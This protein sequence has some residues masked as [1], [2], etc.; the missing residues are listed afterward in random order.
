MKRVA[1]YFA[2]ADAASVGPRPCPAR[3]RGDAET[4]FIPDYRDEGSPRAPRATAHAGRVC[5]SGFPRLAGQHERYVAEQL[6]QFR[7]G[8][9]S[10]D[11]AAMMC[12]NSPPTFRT[13]RS[14]RCRR[15]WHGFASRWPLRPGP[16]SMDTCFKSSN[17]RAAG[18]R[19]SLA[20][21]FAVLLCQPLVAG[22]QA[23]AA[24]T[25]PRAELG[26]GQRATIA[27][28]ERFPS[29]LRRRRPR[30]AGRP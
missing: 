23:R 28:R 16:V 30:P 15:S 20:G 29:R 17:P 24:S 12:A 7:A 19:W 14:M 1:G 3:R 21:A 9:R 2:R 22:A 27:R 11:P 18:A 8:S 5:P 4:I 10:S 13:T 25:P 6:R 26:H